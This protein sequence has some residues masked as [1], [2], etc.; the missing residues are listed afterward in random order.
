MIEQD[1]IEGVVRAQAVQRQAKTLLGL[2][3]RGAG[4]RAGNVEHE[5]DL[6]RRRVEG[7]GRER[8]HHGQQNMGHAI[9]CLME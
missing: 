1:Q 8:R 9:A 5:N 3:D 2:D 7:T 4:H 6:A